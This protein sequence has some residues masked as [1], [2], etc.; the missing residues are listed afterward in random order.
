MAAQTDDRASERRRQAIEINSDGTGTLCAARNSSRIR[1]GGGAGGRGWGHN[2]SSHASRFAID[3][4]NDEW[5]AMIAQR[6]GRNIKYFPLYEP[7]YCS[8]SVYS[9]PLATPSRLH[10]LRSVWL[11]PELRSAVVGGE[12]CATEK[13]ELFYRS[14]IMAKVM[15]APHESLLAPLKSRASAD[16]ETISNEFLP[17]SPRTY[18]RTPRGYGVGSRLGWR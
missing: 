6:G 10:L 16:R 14:Y 4:D 15:S 11:R 13:R 17:P 3:K 2:P 12:N 9:V 5:Q 7:L 1:G 8:S 18:T